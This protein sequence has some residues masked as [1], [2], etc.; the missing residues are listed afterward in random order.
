MNQT[1]CTY[2]IDGKV[3]HQ[4]PLVIGQVRQLMDTLGNITLPAYIDM[5]GIIAL[6]GD[7]LPAA[8]AVILTPEGMHLKDK[9]IEALSVE[10]AYSMD[11]ETT[12]K[13]VEDFFDLNPIA[14]VLGRL[15]GMVETIQ[16]NMTGQKN[17]SVSSQE[18]TS[19]GG[20]QSFGDAPSEN[21]NPI[22]NTE[23]GM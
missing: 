6:L 5:P 22:L 1:P 23:D 14:S 7:K 15:S 2:N 8:L 13:A 10:L 4:K 11:I 21:A 16:I 9:D 3:Y 18:G 19:Q 20:T 12:M 17:L